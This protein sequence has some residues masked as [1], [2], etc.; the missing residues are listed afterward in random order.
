MNTP[1]STMANGLTGFWMRCDSNLNV[2]VVNGT[3]YRLLNAKDACTLTHILSY[4][5]ARQSLRSKLYAKRCNRKADNRNSSYPRVYGLIGLQAR[6]TSPAWANNIK[7]LRW[8]TL[9][10]QVDTLLNTCSNHPFSRIVGL[11]D[12]SASD[13]VR[14]FRN[15]RKWRAEQ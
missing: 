8:K 12:G 9:R 3:M 1:K 14:D 2:R 13:T 6:Y 15:R 5:F 10:A 4:R 11:K 7:L